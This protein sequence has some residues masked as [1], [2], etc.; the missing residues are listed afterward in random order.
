MSGPRVTK[1][2][3][4]QLNHSMENI[5]NI[6][7]ISNFVLV[8]VYLTEKV[9]TIHSTIFDTFIDISAASVTVIVLFIHYPVASCKSCI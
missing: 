3:C 8:F 1:L 5:T 2:C 4:T 9:Y 7:N 6:A